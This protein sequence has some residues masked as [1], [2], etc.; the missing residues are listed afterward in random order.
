MSRV[1]FQDVVIGDEGLLR[2]PFGSD[3]KKSLFVPKGDKTY[4]VYI[5]ENILFRNN[6]AGNYYISEEYYNSK[7]HRYAVHENDF[8]VTCDGTLGEIYQLK[9]LK[10]KGIISSSLLRI[11]LNPKVIDYDYFYYLW[12]A[13]I[14]KG[15][16]TKANNSVL[17][18]LPGITDIRKYEFELPD[19]KTQKTVSDVLKSLDSRIAINSSISNNLK[20]LAKTIYDYWFLQFEFPNKEGKPYKSSGGKM[21]YNE[22]LKREIPEGWEVKNVGAMCD[23]VLG[24]TPSTKIDEYWNGSINWLNSGEVANFPVVESELKITQKGLDN[25]ATEFM[26]KGTVVAS[27]TGNIRASILA[28]DTCANQSVVGILENN[29]YKKSYI[30]PIIKDAINYY[31]KVST[32]NCQQHIN[33]QTIKDTLVA[34]PKN[35]ILKKYYEQCENIYDMIINNGLESKQLAELRDFLLPMLMNG[36]VTFKEDN[37]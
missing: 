32:G 1:R 18:H 24:G 25:S 11:T 4:K 28:I 12:K 2:G 30:Y 22:E 19:L 3:L 36:Q 10:E 31:L 5:Q 17:K 7:M 13:I 20:S 26:K 21:V 27:I 14:K 37:K 34:I 15:L 9:N 16:V 23:I 8:I 35:D 29:E 6:N 33:K